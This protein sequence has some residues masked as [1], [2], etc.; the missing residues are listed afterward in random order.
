MRSPLIF[1]IFKDNQLI[2]VKQ[3]DQDQI[4]IGHSEEVHVDLDG[5][6]VSPIHCLLERRDSGYYICDLGSQTGT[7]KNGQAVLDEG[8][9]S[10]DEV[11][12]GPFKIVF[13]LGVPKPKAP[14]PGEEAADKLEDT[15]AGIVP[16]PAVAAPVAPPPAPT[17][18]ET[19][20]SIPAQLAPVTT[21]PAATPPPAQKAEPVVEKKAEPVIEKKEEV[22]IAIPTEVP[23]IDEKAPATIAPPVASVAPSTSTTSVAPVTATPAM[24]GVTSAASPARPEIRTGKVS[25]KKEKKVKTFAPASEIQDLKTYLKPGKGPTVQVIVA[26]K[27]RIL[28]TYNFKGNQ[29]VHVNLGEDKPNSIALPDG[30]M[31]KGFQILDMAGGLKVNTAADMKIEMVASQGLVAIEDLEKN[32]RAQ[33]AGGGYSIRV[34]QNEMLCL[35][36]P[37]GYMNL[38]I[39]FVPQ[40]PVVPITSVM[41]SGSEMTGM[42]MSLV[43]VGLLALYISATT[44]KDWE[45]NKQEEVQRI[46]QVIF[47]KT[48]TPPPKP[49]P[50]P[51]PPAP[52]P[53]PVQQPTPTPTPKKVVVNDNDK[54]AQE[55]KPENKPQV[56]Q[57][58]QQAA[59]ASEVAPKETKDRTKKFTSTRQGGAVKMGETA[60][61]NAQSK[62]KDLSKVGLFS[63]FGGGGNRGKIDQAYSG[64]GEVLG[65]ADKATGTSGFNEN[66]AGDDLGSKFK[67]SGAGGKGTATQ[68]IA[69]VGTKGRGSGQSAYGASEG[70]CSKSQVA[71]EGGGMEESFDGTIDK[72]AIR[73]VI[74]AKLHEVKSCY[75][76]ALNTKAKGTRLE[77]KVILGW[78]IV[79]QGQARNVKVKSSTLGDKGVEN[80]IRDRL[81]S[82]TFPE[83]PAGLVA[84]IEAYPFVLNQQ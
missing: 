80:C 20:T 38:Y 67:D 52:S 8:I 30:I 13:F 75:E 70:F 42:V 61:A 26:W 27:E 53:T 76:R 82:W 34:D 55:K 35:T 19:L 78:E 40:A 4:V 81:A 64:Q 16:A 21:P 59:K 31:P 73:R 44:P 11:T 9:A 51:T 77:G 23:K 17:S 58:A 43:I 57:K 5:D 36:L 56:S 66:R 22:K 14:P 10:G 7:F 33:R 65:M 71:I 3:F 6:G 48:P 46:A 62:N 29:S 79:A 2:G 60:S 24:G 45:T 54:K 63:A 68:G 50:T 72:E 1:R 84:V 12:V 32:G 15:A 25:F 69:G 18:T 49:S 41:L 83:P 47:D 28:N 74:R 39:R 37:G